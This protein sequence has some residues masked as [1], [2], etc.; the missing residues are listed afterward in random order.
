MTR[1][2][3]LAATRLTD[4]GALTRKLMELESCGFVRRYRAY[5]KKERGALYQLVDNY[6]L[7]YYKFL[8]HGAEDEHCWE[9]SADSGSLNAWRG[10]A[11][12]RVCLEHVPQIKRALGISGV[13]TETS[14]WSCKADP[15]NGIEGSQIDLLIARRD[16]VINV[17][18]MKYARSEFSVTKD[19]EESLRRKVDDF[20][21]LTK[22][23]SAVHI[24]LVTTYGL[25]DG[26][27]SGS[28]QSV[29]TA[30]D[31]FSL[32]CIS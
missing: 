16:Q 19:I 25:K 15:D 1:E 24:T 29:I 8:A 21:T 28:V 14:A 31:L 23:R 18:E 12:E 6:T 22:T 3:I 9:N 27:Y 32:E 11:F 10:L 30:D 26:K 17:C 4:S 2:E 7:F 20:R 13:L 5:G